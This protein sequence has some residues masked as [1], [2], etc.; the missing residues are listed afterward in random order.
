MIKSYNEKMKKDL[1][2]KPYLFPMPVLMIATYGE[3]DVVDVMNMAWGG[4]CSD[5][6]VALNISVGHKTTKNIKKRGAFTVSV[7]DASHMLEA[8]YF[9]MVSGN[10]AADKFERTGLTAMKSTR[11]DAPIIQEFLLTLE[12]KVVEAVNTSYGFRVLGEIV[13]TIADESII[14]DKG[15]VVPSKINAFVFDQATKNYYATGEKLET[16]GFS[17]SK[18]K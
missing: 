14:D 12:C 5:K 13:N 17:L 15:N 6:M 3:N 16:A 18:F 11:V 7:A 9:G 1:G 10:D 2:V 8:D 4:I